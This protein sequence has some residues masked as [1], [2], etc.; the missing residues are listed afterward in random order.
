MYKQ[1]ILFNIKRSYLQSETISRLRLRTVYPIYLPFSPP[2][3]ISSPHLHSIIFYL[4]CRFSKLLSFTNPLKVSSGDK[5]L[6]KNNN[7]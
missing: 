2:F 5:Q 7:K 1:P 4:L 6:K 3:S